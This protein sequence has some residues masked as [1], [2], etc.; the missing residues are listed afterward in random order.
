MAEYDK[1]RENFQLYSYCR[2]NGHEDFLK[3]TEQNL[4]FYVGRQWSEA[5]LAALAADNRPH[6]TVN[7]V[8]RTSMAVLGELAQHS[9]DVR[10]SAVD[11]QFDKTAEALDRLYV[12][13]AIENNK[14]MLDHKVRMRG[15]LFGR[16]FYDIRVD[17][18][19]NLMG[20]V[21]IT[22]PRIQNVVLD[23]DIEDDDPKTWSRFFR[24]RWVSYS[25]LK[26]TYGASAADQVKMLDG[27]SKF[28]SEDIL[29]QHILSRRHRLYGTMPDKDD[30][31]L[32][33]FR[34]IEQQYRQ[35]THKQFFVDPETGDSAEVPDD[36]TREQIARVVEVTGVIVIR[37]KTKAI[38]WC[39]TCDD[40]VL[41][42]D[43]S[44]YRE[45]TIVP[46]MPFFT[47]GYTFGLIDQQIDP[48]RLLNK[49]LSQELH[50]LS[51]TANS[52]WKIRHGALKNM[53]IEQLEE[54]GAKTGLILELDDVAAAEKIQPN[55]VPSGYDNLA[56]SALGFIQDTGGAN[57]AMF[58]QAATS[59]VP[60]KAIV[61]SL[62]RGPIN[63]SGAL[64]AFYNAN[65]MLADRFRDL[66]RQYYTEERFVRITDPLNGSAEQV[67]INQVD[68]HG[69][70]FNDVTSGD[71]FI[72]VIP[73]PARHSVE[74]NA[75]N[76][77]VEL[78]KDLGVMIP[79][80][81]LLSVSSLPKRSEVIER[82]REATGGDMSPEQQRLRE[83]ELAA[84]EAEVAQTRA[85][86]ISTYAQARL[87]EARALRAESD[88]ESDG[89]AMQAELGF[90]RLE[91]E[92]ER[93]RQRML[94]DAKKDRRK[95][96][97]DL[98]KL[99][100][101]AVNRAEDRK[102]NLAAKKQAAKATS[103][104]AAKKTPAKKPTKKATR[105]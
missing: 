18:E 76:Q 103:K 30:N 84:A 73:A 38:R 65:K 59:E 83:L 20:K 45:F 102:V 79:D 46:Y 58:G 26:H 74:Q 80:D 62:N 40:T 21:K 24:T 97:L 86:V 3:R 61:E 54:A 29:L 55:N 91:H 12:Y 68:E 99:E 87:A 77:M 13:T 48:Q 50:I 8:F 67:V 81:V 15:L 66:V 57:P 95:T 49:A 64:A 60:G 72:N 2:E 51:T 34:L 104:G 100:F 25:D 52:G 31:N 78:R 14:E 96:A 92:R 43:W 93:D 105:T 89:R 16:G 90:A 22:A 6:L 63:L 27:V 32:P 4:R 53:T 36:W 10:F 69:E 33:R 101:E 23:P 39:V 94:L 42:D 5:E 28:D 17:F 44:P 35:V 71:Y 56:R 41:H 82:V 19:D 37:R 11:P 85:G 88:A 70:L 98:T 47:D 1:A 7:Q 75:F 9:A